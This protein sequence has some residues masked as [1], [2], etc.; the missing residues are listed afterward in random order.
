MD[1]APLIVDLAV[2]LGATGAVSLLF[3]RMRQ[4]AVL[5]YL[6]AGVLVGPHTPPF[7]LVTDLA[8]I[9]IWAELG[10]IFLMFSMGLEF[11]FRKLAHVG[12]SAVAIASFDVFFLLGIGF[13]AGRLFGWSF[14][15]SLFLGAMLSIASTTIIF[16]AF[17]EL[18][19]KKRRFTEV[20]FG[21]LIVED[22]FAILLLV[23][24]TMMGGSAAFSGMLLLSSA[25]KLA[26]VVGSWF[27][28]GYFVVPRFMKHVG[29]HGT[30]E[31]VTLLSIALCL[32][33]VALAS[34]YGYS[35]ALG[36]FIMG[37]ILAETTES[38]R[39][40]RLITPLKNTFAAVFFVS[41]GM[42]MDPRIFLSHFGVIATI[43]MIA[44][45]GKASVTFL[46]AFLTG[47][48]LRT[49][50]QVGLSLGQIGEFSFIIAG[51]G[52][53][54]GVTSDFLF[55]VGV[56]VALITTLTT[57]YMVRIA[58]SL[59]GRL[60]DRLPP[61]AGLL[62]SRYSSWAQA[63]AHAH[64]LGRK[65]ISK[66]IFRWVVNGLVVTIVFLAI[67]RVTAGTRF[68]GGFGWL[69]SILFSLPF[70]WAMLTSFAERRKAERDPEP[71]FGALSVMSRVF[72]LAWVG[73][74]S[75]E[76]FEAKYAL[77]V[78]GGMIALFF[79]F[80]YH[81]LEASYAWFE[82]NFLSPFHEKDS[83]HRIG[84]PAL[85]PWDAHL[86]RLYAHPNANFTGRRLDEIALR[87][88]YGVNVVVIR[89][90]SEAIVSPKPTE[91]LFPGDELLVLGT[92]EQIEKIRASIEVPSVP[93]GHSE[94]LETYVLKSIWIRNA[95]SP[96]LGVTIRNSGIREKYGAMVVGIE[97][98]GERLMNPDSDLSFQLEDLVWMVGRPD[99]IAR[100]F[101]LVSM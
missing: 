61:R 19:L 57:P 96:L 69:A 31:M 40:E 21:A 4:P 59:S 80:F 60:E 34:Y 24:L 43:S 50:T 38:H 74:L 89:R 18:G 16:K 11:S 98:K 42:K 41:V 82:K 15:D 44:I 91:I 78:T 58:A 53:S 72:A 54:L 49:S 99:S 77:L 14:M 20:V 75:L 9:K 93:I 62:L 25:A 26:L 81:R 52:L 100:L 92:D 13:G 27:L 3:R 73:L 12:F 35:V 55:P 79:A 48:T 22:L 101:A 51:L 76:F 2:I 37:S 39:I 64:P 47:Q 84:I 28:I 5:G 46:G 6:V 30:D 68:A 29:R 86:V 83:E 10:V 23:A 87:K 63:S 71:G 33:L 97:R 67:E 1:L 90:G 85:A 45:L 94:R 95:R 36:A 65:H 70:I 8:G 7:S 32:G 88:K 66:R 17:E 56:A